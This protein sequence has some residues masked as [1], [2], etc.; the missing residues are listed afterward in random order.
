VRTCNRN[1]FAIG[2]PMLN[3]NSA[4]FKQT[5]GVFTG[6]SPAW[7]RFGT[8][9]SFV[10]L[11]ENIRKELQRDYRHQRFPIGEINRQVG[12]HQ[13][14]F[15]LTLSYAKHDYDAHFN[16]N[17]SRTVYLANGFYPQGHAL[18][19]FIEEFHQD[20]DVNIYFDYNLGFF[21]ENEI[22]RLKASLEFL[23]GEILRQPSLPVRQ[24]QIIPDAELKKQFKFHHNGFACQNIK[25]GIQYVKEMYDVTHISDIAFDER[26]EASVCLIEANNNIH[27]ELVAGKRVESLLNKGIILYHVCYE[28]SDLYQTMEKFIAK[29]ASV[30]SEPKPALLF[31]NQLVTFLNTHLGLVEL[32]EEAKSPIS[33][34]PEK[35]AEQTIAITATFT[36]EPLKESLDFWMSELDLPFEVEFAPYNQVFQQLLDSSSMLSKNETGINVVL[37]RLEDWGKSQDEVTVQAEIEQNVQNFVQALQSAVKRHVYLVCVCP[38]SPTTTE[39]G[40]FSQ[41]MEGLLTSELDG[42]SNVHLTNS[43]ELLSRYPVSRFDDQ[44]GDELGHIPYTPAFFTALG[45][46]IARKIHAIKR[47]P[48]KVIVLDCDGTLWQGICA[49]DGP[50]NLKIDSPHQALQTFMLAQQQAG[51]VLCLCSKNQEA[52]V[53]AVFAQ[54][55]D[56][57]LLREHLV[58]WRINWQPKSANIKSLAEELNLGLSSFIFVDD[59]PVE[60]AEVQAHCPAVT[61]IQLPSDS[62]QIP[63]FLDHIWA[64][65]RLKTTTEDQQRTQYYQQNQE[66]DHWHQ[67]AL[68]F[69]DFLAGLELE[70][71]ISTMTASQLNRVSQ[72][73]LRTNQFNL[74]T[75]RR[76]AAEIQQLYESSPFESLVV[77]VRDR[78]GDYGLVGVILFESVANAIRVD[79]FLLSCRALGRGVEHQMLAQLGKIA[80]ERQFNSIEILYRPT[81]KNQPALDFLESIGSQF[82][83]SAPDGWQFN[84][85]VHLVSELTYSPP[86]EEISPLPQNS[87]TLLEENRKTEIQSHSALFNRIAT[88]LSDAEHILKRIK[89]QNRQSQGAT[90]TYKAPRTTEEELLA[91]IWASVLGLDRVGIHDNFFSVGG[92]SLLGTQVMSRI[93]DT[94]AI[95]LPLHLLFEL[96][97]IAQLSTRLNTSPRE[98][99]LPPITPVNRSKPL[100]LSFAQ[101]RLWFLDQLEGQSA[102]YNIVA[103]VHLEGQLDP[104]TLEQSFQVLVQRHESLRTTFPTPN[105]VPLVQIEEEAFQLALLDLRALSKA[106]QDSE[107]QRL[108]KEEAMRPFDLATG[109]LFRATLFQL[110]ATSHIL[111]VNM[112]HIIAD[113]WSLGVFVR[114][115]RVIYEAALQGQPSP[116]P[117][118]PIQYVDFAHWQRQWLTGEMLE[119]QV[120]YWKG[121]LAGVP[122]LLELPTDY[123]RPPIQRYQGASLS[124]SLSPKL[125]TQ[126]KHL[127]QE[128]GTTLFM[129]LWS[130]FA[131]LLSRYSGQ[132]DIVIGSP[133][134]NRTMS[135]IESLIGFFVNTLVLRLDLTENPPFEDVLLKA[136]QVALEAYARLSKF[137]LLKQKHIP[138]FWILQL[139]KTQRLVGLRLLSKSQ[140]TRCV[141]VI[142]SPFFDSLVHCQ[143][144][145]EG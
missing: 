76:T 8:D 43:S 137:G 92:H 109:P 7:F 47:N 35:R 27:I 111:Q 135:Q 33:E 115:W 140:K 41:Q 65:D 42:I 85:P 121:Q 132:S 4:A 131:I 100:Q 14:L 16:S 49:E 44:H 120:K 24:L 78:F 52:D 102:T 83:Q 87:L 89:S 134:A 31:K 107:I 116:L 36:A 79:T 57:S 17:P 2:L 30:V 21:N 128:T 60:C 113:A 15:D 112:H 141:N 106:E 91:G 77:E 70:I 144:S 66:R 1:D 133:I 10:E 98:S 72:L 75:I 119:E 29:G 69:A 96:P 12:L 58:S 68:T 90:E 11:M 143:G 103:A 34:E 138:A 64:F 53:W 105:A 142:K 82:K 56:M 139:H 20:D 54:R 123:P 136:R 61:T 6:I 37:L 88:E 80:K 104:Q 9:L 86:V 48:Y 18:F 67:D 13:Q 63:P 97:T 122:A 118:L 101:Q 40:N 145:I 99:S 45:T 117:P 110:G 108:L 71:E 114:E 19:V 74:T 25:E 22:E 39:H 127:S 5:A 3:R 28:V 130:A 124:F 125:T 95:G 38:A 46:L 50:L 84:L 94:F 51:R 55:S 93:R 129:T 81:P 62:N 32:L 26:Q 23:L 126:L 73:T 59:N